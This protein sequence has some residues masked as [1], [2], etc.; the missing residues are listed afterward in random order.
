M[1]SSTVSMPTE[2][3]TSP[4]GGAS[5][6]PRTDPCVIARGIST[7]DSTPPSDSAIAKLRIVP[8][9]RTTDDVGVPAEVFR[10]R[11]KDEVSAELDGPLQ[12]GAREGVVHDRER[13]RLLRDLGESGDIEHLEQRVRGRL[14][15]DQLRA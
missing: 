4:A 8:R 3:R 14:D 15:P 6:V 11:V 2:R 10:R 12:I 7:S 1:R 5:L 13:P 9:E